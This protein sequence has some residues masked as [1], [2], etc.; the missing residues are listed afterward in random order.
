[1]NFFPD[2]AKDVLTTRGFDVVGGVV[3]PVHDDYVNRKPVLLEN[4]L[5]EHSS[6]IQRYNWITP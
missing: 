5:N 2:V 3:A 1:M 4:P 6:Y